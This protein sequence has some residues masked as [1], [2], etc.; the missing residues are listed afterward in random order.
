VSDG[1]VQSAGKA[2]VEGKAALGVLGGVTDLYV[3]KGKNVLHVDLESERPSDDDL[4]ALLLGRSGKLRAPTLRSGARL[5]VG[6]NQDMLA[7][8][9][10]GG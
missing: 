2:P 7:S 1:E 8:V 10:M 9:L 5:L 3:A 4:L 6:Y